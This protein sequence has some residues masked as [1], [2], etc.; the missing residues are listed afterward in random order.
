MKGR[1]PV[2]GVM[3]G[4]SASREACAA[5]EAF[6]RLVAEAGW[7]LLCGG[8]PVGIMDAAARGAH[9]AGGLAVGIL[10]RRGDSPTEASTSLDLAIFTGMGDARNAINVLSSQVLVVC[11]GGPGT[12]SEVALALKAGRPAILLGWDTPARIFPEYVASGRLCLAATPEEA[13]D[14]VAAFLTSDR[15]REDQHESMQ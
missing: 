15:G 9:A 10:P 3:G 5:A 8:R 11:P 14:L 1:R 13:R 6:G 2:V 4:G 12:I 7:I